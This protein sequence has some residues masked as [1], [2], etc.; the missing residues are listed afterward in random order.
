LVKDLFRVRGVL[1]VIYGTVS[2]FAAVSPDL[3]RALFNAGLSSSLICAGVYAAK[4]FAR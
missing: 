1:L 4:R 3:N 2:V